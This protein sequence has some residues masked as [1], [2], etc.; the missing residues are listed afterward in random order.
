MP[1]KIKKRTKKTEEEL[2]VTG[3]EGGE[4]GEESPQLFDEDGMPIR[5]EEFDE[6]ANFGDMV[7]AIP[8]HERDSF[9]KIS[10]ETANWIERN[11]PLAMGLFFLVLAAPLIVYGIWYQS[12][13]SAIAEAADVTEAIEAFH[14][15]VQDTKAMTFYETNEKFAKPGTVYPS[16][17][18]KWNAVYKEADEALKNHSSDDLGVSARYAKAG[19]AYQL[20]KY[21]EAVT[22]YNE[23]LA[24]E[25]GDAL[26][27]FATLG[28]AMSQAGKGDVDGAVATFDKLGAMSDDY[29]AFARYHKGR[30]LEAAGKKDAAKEAYNALLSSDSNTSYKLDVERRLAT[31]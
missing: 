29:A 7:V 14:Y 21:D 24:D 18:A 28:L 3:A 17:E 8:E 9:E 19:A 4:E 1:K 15:P 6:V 31:M 22:L 27:L 30:V 12:Q 25:R 10:H 23:V 26:H 2:E 20:G 13:Q 16:H 11:R 5:Q